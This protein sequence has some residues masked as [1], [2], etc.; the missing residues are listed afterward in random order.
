MNQIAQDMADKADLV[1]VD[2]QLV[3]KANKGD[4]YTI[5]DV[6]NM[7]NNTV[8]KTQ[9]ETDKDGIVQELES[10]GT[11]IG[12]NAE[13]IGLKADKT[14]LNQVEN[15]LSTQIANVDIKADGVITRVESVE[16]EVDGLEIGGRN[17]IIRSTEEKGTWINPSGQVVSANN[18]STSDYIP[19]KPN[20]DY[21]FTKSDSN[22]END[23]GFF[24]WAWCDEDK[25][26]ISR[27]ANSSNEFLWTTPNNVH[28]V[29]ISYPDDSY[30]KF[31][32]GN[33]A[34]DWTP[35]PE[36]TQE[37]INNLQ[38]RVS[39]AEG[40][41]TTLA[42]EVSLKASQ[43]TVNALEQRVSTAEGELQVLPGQINAKVSK[44]GVI[45]AINATPEQ[46]LIDFDKVKMTGELEAKHIKSLAG[47]NIND[48]FVVDS[49]GK[50]TIG[51][52]RVIID[53]KGIKIIRPDGAVWMQDGLVNNEYSIN[54]YDPYLMTYGELTGGTGVK[55]KA[56]DDM[57]FDN[58]Y[59]QQLGV[60][61]G[62][63]VTGL[64]NAYKDVR[65][66]SLGYSVRFQR[67][68]FVHS[69]RYLKITYQIAANTNV[70]QHRF[71]L[72][73]ITSVPSGSKPIQTQIT[74]ANGDRGTKHI[75]I[76]LGKPSFTV[77]SFDIRLGWTTKG[78][79]WG[80]KDSI[81]RFRI[82][83]II[84]TDIL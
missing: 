43:S 83:S 17:L 38:G 36:D 51:N 2:G 71:R 48:Q 64:P 58:W 6:D 67:Y 24:R 22:L 68:E 5:E 75:V 30:P 29:R 33:K 55:F 65:D 32:K 77:R 11:R 42:G 40:E 81:L 13:A 26:Y 44:D 18:H 60:L 47:L 74:Y 62:R 34:T 3:S 12:Q 59:T 52:N 61:D 66:A 57:S 39:T 45:G 73:E 25:N 16:A 4:V 84:Q 21:M 23:A 19:V 8:S 9:Y 14:E 1:Y 53:G 78:G 15:S 35:A 20:T 79:D 31:E 50:V 28:Y 72:E 54:G 80:T 46:L 76:D 63:G 69:A 27:R 37:D 41:I 82:P 70:F 7:I 10:Q 56:F 49:T